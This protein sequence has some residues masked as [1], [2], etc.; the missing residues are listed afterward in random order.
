MLEVKDLSVAYGGLR[1]LTNVT[2]S[3]AE[4]RFVTLVGPNGAGKSTL[5]K[6]ICGVVPPVSGTITFRSIYAPEIDPGSTGIEAELTDVRFEDRDAPEMRNAT[7]NG[8][9]QFFYQRGAPAQRFP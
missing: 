5:F 4:G 9:F 6:T 3:V 8:W 2:L 1:A 7:L